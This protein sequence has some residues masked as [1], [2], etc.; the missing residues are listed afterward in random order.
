MDE[1]IQQNNYD[2]LVKLIPHVK[3]LP[4][5][6]NTCIEFKNSEDKHFSIIFFSDE[7]NHSIRIIADQFSTL[8]KIV[9]S[10][11]TY[12]NAHYRCPYIYGEINHVTEKFNAYAL[13]DDLKKV[14]VDRDDPNIN[15]I[16][17]G[18][19]LELKAD[20]VDKVHEYLL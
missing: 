6:K 2:E 20:G 15:S 18:Y 7:R 8:T 9:D 13:F 17:S 12:K 5:F 1:L 19:L 10:K 14:R 3:T 16:V 4:K 11:R